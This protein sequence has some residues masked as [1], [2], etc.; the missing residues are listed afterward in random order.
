VF[1]SCRT[2]LISFPNSPKTTYHS[3][4]I[5]S[6]FNVS[7]YWL[8]DGDGGIF[9]QDI[10]AQVAKIISLFKSLNQPFQ[11]CALNQLENLANLNNMM[12][13]ITDLK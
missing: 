2:G 11:E 9:K 3:G 10:N 4:D 8:R 1:V 13:G 7:E 12:K 6:E 5:I